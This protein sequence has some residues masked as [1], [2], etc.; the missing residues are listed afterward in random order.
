MAN[1]D[2]SPKPAGCFSYIWPRRQPASGNHLLVAIL[3]LFLIWV[4]DSAAKSCTS[5]RARTPVSTQHAVVQPSAT[6]MPTRLTVTRTA[7]DEPTRTPYPVATLAI[8]RTRTNTPTRLAP[9]PTQTA[10]SYRVRS[11]DT[12]GAIARAHAVSLGALALANNITDVDRIEVGQVLIMP[13]GAS[14][15]D[16]VWSVATRLPTATPI[17]RSA[18]VILEPTSPPA[19]APARRC[20]KICTVGKACGDSCIA[21]NKQCHKPP[22][23]A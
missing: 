21:R 19:P 22:G 4:W 13:A 20:C 16:P 12:L 9:S 1:R 15:P 8:T 11:G 2:T 6:P 17:T 18:P 14:T 5:Q 23:C 10:L 7:T 3:M